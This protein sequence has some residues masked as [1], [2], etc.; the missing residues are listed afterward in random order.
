MKLVSINKRIKYNNYKL[1]FDISDHLLYAYVRILPDFLKKKKKIFF[2]V[3]INTF[4]LWTK[5]KKL[6]KFG[7]SFFKFSI[8]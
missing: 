3:T 1:I 4:V 7:L 5:Q 8:V 2:V 6:Y